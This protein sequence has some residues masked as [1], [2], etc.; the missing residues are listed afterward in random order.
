MNRAF[1]MN[2]EEITRPEKQGFSAP[3][4]SWFKC[5]SIE[6]VRTVLFNPMVPIYSYEKSL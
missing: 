3:D 1:I 5:E 2:P 6:F 4:A